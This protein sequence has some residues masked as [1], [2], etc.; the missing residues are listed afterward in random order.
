MFWLNLH[1]PDHFAQRRA[2]VRYND[3]AM[4]V[5]L[6]IYKYFI[7][8]RIAQKVMRIQH[9][10]WLSRGIDNDDPFLAGDLKFLQRGQ[11]HLEE[12]YISVYGG[13]GTNSTSTGAVTSRPSK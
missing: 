11:S 4:P 8:E 10:T 2:H 7:E 3:R 6:Q 13:Y 9:Q 5:G 12:A 1:A